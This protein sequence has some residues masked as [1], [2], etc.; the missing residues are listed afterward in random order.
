MCPWWMGDGDPA[1]AGF[2]DLPPD[3]RRSA[4][5]VLAGRCD[6][7]RLWFAERGFTVLPLPGHQLSISASRE[8]FADTFGSTDP[9]PGTEFEIPVMTDAAGAVLSGTVAIRPATS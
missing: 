6:P 3:A 9:E 2:G 5:V 8:L 4:L 7:V 1:D